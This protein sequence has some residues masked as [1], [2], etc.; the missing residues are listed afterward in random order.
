METRCPESAL[1]RTE[2]QCPESRLHAYKPGLCIRC[3]FSVHRDQRSSLNDS[4]HI[5][6][7]LVVRSGGGTKRK[8]MSRHARWRHDIQL[9][10]RTP[11][12][13][14]TTLLTVGRGGGRYLDMPHG[15]MTSNCSCV[16][17]HWCAPLSCYTGSLYTVSSARAYSC[18]TDFALLLQRFKFF[19][20]SSVRRVQR[21]FLG[22]S[23]R[24]ATQDRIFSFC[25]LLTA[26]G[27]NL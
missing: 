18:T 16:R 15:V 7:A 9:F 26:A 2:P 12:L 14:F 23:V 8:Q 17:L 4:Q 19:L 10:L 1:K 22:S 5:G 6:R 13:L 21:F 3:I 25:S 20:G 24:P 27:K 11:A